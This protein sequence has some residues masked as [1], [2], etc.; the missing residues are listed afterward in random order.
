MVLSFAF[1]I[2]A[3]FFFVCNRIIFSNSNLETEALYSSIP[4]H[5]F[6]FDN[7]YFWFFS[8]LKERTFKSHEVNNLEIVILEEL[9]KCCLHYISFCFLR[10]NMFLEIS[11]LLYSQVIKNR[12]F[13]TMYV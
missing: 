6:L 11:N 13:I 1:L 7:K 4:Q 9:N 5:S 2:S 8:H 12:I 3:L 10:F